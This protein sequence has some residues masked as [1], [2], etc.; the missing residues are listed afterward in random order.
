[1]E[2]L[3]SENYLTPRITEHRRDFRRLISWNYFIFC[4]LGNRN[5]CLE[6]KFFVI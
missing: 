4:Y 3:L 6:A 2:H 5:I 1:M